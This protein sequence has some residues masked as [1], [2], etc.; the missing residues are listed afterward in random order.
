MQLKWSRNYKIGLI[1]LILIV[2]SIY[3]LLQ[4]ESIYGG[5]AGDMASAIIVSG[6]THPPGYPL[7][8]IF[9]IIFTKILSFGTYA[10]RIGFL[11]SIPAVLTIIIL[12]DLLNYLTKKVFIAFLAGLILAFTYPFWLYAEVVEVFSLNN[13]FTVSILWLLFH[14]ADTARAKYLYFFSFIFGLS[15]THHHIILFLTPTIIYLLFRKKSKITKKI[16]LRS[17]VLFSL[18]LIP[19]F[20]VFFASQ[21]SS[22]PVNW[23]GSPTFSNFIA[24][25]SRATYGTFQSGENIIHD[26]LLKFIGIWAFFD[27]VY[28]DFRLPGIVFIFLGIYEVY[29][30]QKNYF[31]PLF[32]GSISYLFFLFYAAFPLNNNFMLATFERFLLP[33]YIFLIF[34]ISFG[35]F[36]L[37]IIFKKFT[38][39]FFV[40]GKVKSFSNLFNF[41]LLI[42]PLSLFFL[43]YPKISILKRDFT[44]EN[45]GQ[46]ILNSLPQNSIL[47]LSTD[48]PLFDTQYVYY[49]QKYRQDVKLIHYK[50]LFNENDV[51]KLRQIYPEVIFVDINKD[52]KEPYKSFLDYNYSKYPIYSKLSI[53]D[54]GEWIPYG[55]VFRFVKKDR[56]KPSDES[57]LAD[58]QRLWSQYQVPT[59]GSLSKYQNLMLSDVLTHYAVAHEEIGFWAAK[60]KYSEVAE[61]HL[62]AAEKL[63]P[64]D[65]DSY[66]I[67]AQLYIVDKRCQDARDQINEVVKKRKDDMRINFLQS[68]N[69]AVCFK[70]KDKA[71]FYRNLYEENKKENDVSLRKL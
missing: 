71:A 40:S 38:S 34:F 4:V 8:T 54:S 48:T 27:F 18:G 12:Y 43:S 58:N 11:S 32:L 30:Y 31:M 46:D 13:L 22:L 69:Y 53:G 41:T 15:L 20:Y 3:L 64:A 1:F 55:L 36:K 16:I 67:L 47:F 63:F 59:Q 25:V 49:A 45:F 68:V 23:M 21:N 14:W 10:W 19:Y 52:S 6:I 50:N 35:I 44:A 17:F 9:G 29:K 33:A 60:R 62:L 39:R 42:F 65:L 66:I 28:K 5:D 37:K 57:V 51:K 24:L 2:S 26:P 7:Y 61:N 70:D 56:D